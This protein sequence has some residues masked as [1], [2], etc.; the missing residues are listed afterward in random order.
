MSNVCSRGNVRGFLDMLE[1]VSGIEP[2]SFSKMPF[3]RS[4]LNRVGI[5]GGH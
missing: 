1:I 5:R 4:R 3:D 2:K